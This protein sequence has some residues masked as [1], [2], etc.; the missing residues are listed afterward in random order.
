VIG[1][2]DGCDFDSAV[3]IF[4]NVCFL[5]LECD[6]VDGSALSDFAEIEGRECVKEAAVG[7]CEETCNGDKGIALEFEPDKHGGWGIGGGC[8]DAGTTGVIDF[9]Y[10]V[11]QDLAVVLAATLM[12]SVMLGVI[13]GVMLGVMFTMM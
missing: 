3:N 12:G 10:E 6:G 9:D 11:S 13:L 4:L 1:F 2:E 5:G 8:W 7:G